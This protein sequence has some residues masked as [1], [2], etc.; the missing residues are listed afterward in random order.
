MR[1]YSLL[2][3]AVDSKVMNE[4]LEAI[5][6][7]FGQL[8][9]RLAAPELLSDGAAYTRVQRQYGEMQSLARVAADLLEYKNRLSEALN[10]LSDPDLGELAAQ[11]VLE[12][13]AKIPEL[14]ALFEDLTLPK[15][16]A[17]ARDVI[18]E[19][20]AGT[21]GAEAGLFVADMFRMY[22]RYC[23]TLGFKLE[24]L[25]TNESDIG[26]FAKLTAEVR[27][28]GAFAVFKF[29]SGVH[30]V[31]RIPATESAGRIHTST[32][33][34]AV[35]PEAEEVDVHISPADIRVD[36]FRAG[37]HGGQ[38]VNTTDSAVRVVYKEGTAEE[39]VVTCQDGRSQLK[40][41]EKAMTVLRS[42]LFERE[43]ERAM[44]QR[45]EAR[46][47]L[48]GSGERSEKIRTYNYPQNRVTD[49]RLEGEAKNY[50]LNNIIEGDLTEL[51]AALRAFEKETLIA[52]RLEQQ[53]QKVV[54]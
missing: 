38:G 42:R 8:E 28:T 45:S 53:M 34:V 20:R 48:I 44:R 33:T 46:A 10:L 24:V 54:V 47:N 5:L 35:L 9:A 11:D 22:Q 25:D 49:H 43:R 15:D 14:E 19:I 23:E 41:R 36:V 30:R 1:P 16:S 52:E 26:G 50:P 17:D 31:Q 3:F 29:E 40:N 7:E 2:F 27:G 21:G 18:L 13:E 39:I 37:G 12:C 6:A 32:T 51:T 4:S